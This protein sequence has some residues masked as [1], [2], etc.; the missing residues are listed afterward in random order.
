MD[1]AHL[2]ADTFP[3]PFGAS[4]PVREIATVTSERRLLLEQLSRRALELGAADRASC[5]ALGGGGAELGRD[6][7]LF[8]ASHEQETG[9]LEAPTPEPAALAATPEPLAS[10]QRVG[11]VE[12]GGHFGADG[13]EGAAEARADA[14]VRR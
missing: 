8:V 13:D 7:E 11:R 12:P 1:F 3:H 10:G 4:L 5:L 6:L 9:W 2:R 14:G